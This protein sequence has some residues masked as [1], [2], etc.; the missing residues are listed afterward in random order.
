[1]K[2]RCTW[3]AACTD[4]AA[5]AAPKI[6][7][8]TVKSSLPLGTNMPGE[9]PKLYKKWRIHACLRMMC[10]MRTNK[11]HSWLPAGGRTSNIRLPWIV[12]LVNHS[13]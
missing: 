11:Q 3:K 10:W 6:I 5:G 2:L 12:V 4:A 8:I 7:Q 9:V 13:R 1:M